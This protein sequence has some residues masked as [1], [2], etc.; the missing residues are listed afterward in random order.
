ME[1]QR[2]TIVNFSKV[3][4]I[5]LTISFIVL[6]VVGA[7]QALSWSW[8][9]LGLH[10]EVWSVAGIEMEAPLLF[11]LGEVRIFLPVMWDSGIDIMGVRSVPIIGY[12]DFLLTI[13]TIIGIGFAKSVFRLL[14]QNGSPFREDVV[15]AM[16]RFA[17]AML[18]MGALSGVIPFLAAG[19][20]WVLSLIFSYGHA[21]QAESDSTL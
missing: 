17:I 1:K 13:F 20:V 5:L 16:K 21:L 3:I 14:R 2:E 12:A 9:M 7:L 10:N 6:I 18:C 8:S 11:Q 4:Y 15:K 19:I